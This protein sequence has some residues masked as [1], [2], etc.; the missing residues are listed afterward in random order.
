MDDNNPFGPLGEYGDA[1]EEQTCST[2]LDQV[3]KGLD[4]HNS[5]EGWWE[6]LE[7]LDGVTEN[8]VDPP[9]EEAEED[10]DE[11]RRKVSQGPRPTNIILTCLFPLTQCPLPPEWE[12][13][14]ALMVGWN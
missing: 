2:S 4:L 3:S 11:R 5:Q 6:D 14:E 13:V 9:D 7:D 8:E 1:M 12:E 10:D